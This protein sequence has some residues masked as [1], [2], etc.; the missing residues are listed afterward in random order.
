M[1][2]FEYTSVLAQ[3]IN[4]L[5]ET[6]SV[7]GPCDPHL[8]YILKEFDTY[9]SS[10]CLQDTFITEEFIAGWRKTRL[11]DSIRTI[12]NKLS[13][14]R[15]LLL[16]MTRK[17]HKCYIPRLPR[18]R[19]TDFIP[20]IF[21][22][23]EL[24]SFWSAT[25]NLRMQRLKM[26]TSLIALPTVF[27]FLYSTGV[28]VGEALSIRNS[29]TDINRG[30]ILI[31]AT[32][33]NAERIVVIN[34]SMKEVLTNYLFYRNKLPSNNLENPQRHLFVKADGTPISTHTVYCNFRK[35]IEI[36][37]IKYGG[38]ALGPCVHSFRHTYAVHSLAKLVGSGMNIYSALPILSA[39]MG[40]HSLEATEY[41]VRLTRTMFPEIE[42]S[43]SAINSFVY[44]QISKYDEDQN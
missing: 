42:R 43:S 3:Y 19:H 44:P 40:H 16:L 38:R 20:Y 33:N 7:T 1:R 12:H 29:D 37:G 5:I 23:E 28:R 21:T 10:S 39:S 14:W 22:K 34:E 26:D 36:C 35:I 9:A 32:K 41:Y 11:N 2:N 30:H 4:Q 17:G 6:L 27:R 24:S 25:D 31:K 13:I 18:I 15:K 8:P